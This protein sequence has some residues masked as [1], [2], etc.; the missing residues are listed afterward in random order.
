MFTVNYTLLIAII[1]YMLY[2]IKNKINKKEDIMEEKNFKYDAF[3]SYRHCDLDKFVAENLHKIL[4]TYE[5]PKNIKEQLHIEGRTIKR[6][7][8]DQDE[9]P[10][11][12]N[13]EDP[14]IEALK[15]SK[16]LIVICSPRLKDSLWCKKEIQTFKK[17]RGRKN[18]FCVLIEG[19]PS[20]SFPDEVTYDE[21]EII[22]KNGKTKKEKKLVEPLA[23]D[24]RGIDNKEV[25][26]KIKEEKLR[27]IAPMYNLDYDDLKQ[28]HKLRKQ[29][30]ILMTSILVAATCLLFTLYT[31]IM[32]IKI[33]SQQKILKNHQ[34]LSLS[35]KAEEYMKKDSRYNAIKS[36][37]QAL[38]A[39]NGVKMPY[40]PEAEYALS[41]SLGVYNAGS[42]YKAI[43]EIMT[44]GVTDYIKSS[45]NLKYV[46][47]Y[48]ESEEI[49]LCDSKTLKKIAIFNDINGL[50]MTESSFTFTSDD[51][52]A[53]INKEGNI[54]LI[55]TKDGKKIKEIKKENDKYISIKGGNTGKYLTYTNGN[56]LYIYDVKSK[57]V[58][59]NIET[60]DKYMSEIYYS[61][62]DKYVFAST[63]EKGIKI[64]EEEYINVHVIESETSK[65]ISKFTLNAGYLE[66]ML[67][68]DDNLY[69]LS[70]KSIGTSFTMV[71][72]S[73]NYMNGNNNWTKTFA[74]NWGKFITKSNDLA[75][76]NYDTL[77]VLDMSNGNLIETF[78]TS[79]EIINIYSY[80][81]K[82]IYLLFNGDGSVNYINME[83]KNN[84]EYL[85]KFEFNLDK[86]TKVTQ[87]EKGF[88][89]IPQNENRAI[90]YEANSNKKLKEEDIK[91]DYIKDDGIKLSEYDKIKKT[92]NMKNKNLVSK[93][94]YDTKKELLF[95]NYTNES[96]AIY[97]VKDKKL[98]NMI[99]EFG[100]AYHYFGKDK[101]DRIY[102]GDSSNSYILDKNYNKVGH[103]KGLAKLD[104][105]N[106]KV[107]V[108]YNSKYYSLPIYTLDD[109]LK[110]TKK[111]L[112]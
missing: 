43:S 85:G 9:L 84:I 48:D 23:A 18:I 65:E 37:Y 58:I 47:L 81:N 100:K 59:G 74:D 79:S 26:K 52:F 49:T 40:T 73:Y 64:N 19:E 14:I 5:L 55:N 12:S 80:Y 13:L 4:E 20:D 86:Y 75:V 68:K 57:K 101:Y 29:K 11:S 107:I 54:S 82:E 36:S 98:L 33:N 38:T 102:V 44:K 45:Q 1:I 28:R 2:N 96:F 63:K 110:E 62:D 83:Y 106:N 97:N 76:V 90:Y 103:I 41:E 25:L 39:F 71:V 24:V 61:L 50:A 32:L 109:L 69:V 30:Q 99:D 56:K 8:R 66:G 42:S 88:L 95:V 22:L 108:S 72:S 89:L 46:A 104:S 31:S 15:E 87:T 91:L 70:N 35:T 111:F 112:N 60:N 16:Y 94:F 93:I 17:L 67:T 27:L 34:A 105:K 7:F 78:N 6:V 77:K 92:Y 51:I 10:L 3:I 21:E 53:Y